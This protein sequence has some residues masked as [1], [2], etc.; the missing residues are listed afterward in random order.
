VL[1]GSLQEA[2]ARAHLAK[3]GAQ[4]KAYQSQDQNYADLQTAASTPP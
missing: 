3:L 1:Q 4:I 2:Y